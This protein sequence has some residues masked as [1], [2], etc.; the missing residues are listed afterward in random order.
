MLLTMQGSLRGGAGSGSFRII[1]THPDAR[2]V[3]DTGIVGF[4]ASR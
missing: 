4:S 2:G 3:C 1:E